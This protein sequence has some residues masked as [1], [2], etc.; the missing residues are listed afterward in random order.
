M[1]DGLFPLS[2]LS[3]RVCGWISLIGVCLVFITDSFTPLGFGHG[4]LYSPLIL[5]AFI[6]GNRALLLAVTLS[7]VILTIIGMLISP[8]T[9]HSLTLNAILAN[10]ALSIVLIILVATLSFWLLNNLE[11][12]NKIAT[13]LIAT[14]QRLS[15]QH[16]LLRIASEVGHLGGWTV[17]LPELQVSWTDEVASIHRLPLGYHPGVEEA[18]NFYHPDYRQRVSEHIH[19]C[20]EQGTAF[21]DEVQLITHDGETLWV[22][23]MGVAVRD[24]DGNVMRIQGAIQ[25]I[26]QHKQAEQ[27]IKRSHEKFSDLADAM[28]IIV[29]SAEKNGV[30]DYVN[31]AL[32]DFSGIAI[33]ELLQPGRWLNLLHPDDAERAEA[34][35]KESVESGM[36]YVIEF[37]IRRADGE[38]RWHLTRAQPIRDHQGNITKWYG[39]TVDIHEHKMLEREHRLIVERLSERIKNITQPPAATP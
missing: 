18:L 37:R 33:E 1:T 28:P 22:R 9:Q 27:L 12:T 35:W 31:R 6:C 15:E 20:I 21:D 24:R 32:S 5:L 36:D 3:R 13:H 23:I 38:Y 19:R 4:M 34:Y 30:V 2:H 7:A 25:D 17:T 14:Q 39:G 16:Q 11:K 26:S 29:W 10:R 8:V